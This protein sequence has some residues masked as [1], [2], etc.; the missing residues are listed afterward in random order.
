MTKR[1][2]A[3][4]AGG[5]LLV[6]AAAS[7]RA[8]SFTGLKYLGGCSQTQQRRSGALV[9]A[10]SELRFEDQ[11]GRLVC[12]LPLA[13]ARAWVAWEKRTTFGSILRSTALTM[14]AIPLSAGQ[15]DP[16][17]AWSRDTTPILIVQVGEGPGGRTVRWRGPREQLGAIADAI[18]RIAEGA[19]LPQ[20]D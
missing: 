19:A 18:N 8:D 12:V 4:V 11:K 5:M 6:G 17:Q 13:G 10:G 3:F 2:R 1:A 7:A 9:L 15:V 16:T 14:A 20:A